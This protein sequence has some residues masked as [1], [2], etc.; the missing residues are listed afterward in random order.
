MKECLKCEC[1]SIVERQ[2]L[3]SD[4]GHDLKEILVVFAMSE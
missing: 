2:S 1:Y 3:T 4:Y